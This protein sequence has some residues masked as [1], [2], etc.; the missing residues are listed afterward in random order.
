MRGRTVKS[1]DSEKHKKPKKKIVQ[2]DHD[3]IKVFV[4]PMTLLRKGQIQPL[5]WDKV[6][7]DHMSD[8]GRVD[9]TF[10]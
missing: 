10:F 4:Y 8:K 2:L 6:F 1:D 3:K 5:K 9:R 7:A